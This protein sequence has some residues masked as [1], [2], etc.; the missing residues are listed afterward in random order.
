MSVISDASTMTDTSRPATC[1]KGAGGDRLGR[2]LFVVAACLAGVAAGAAQ[3]AASYPRAEISGIADKALRAM[4]QQAVGV[5]PS[6]PDSRLEA[7]RRAREA[8][9]RAIVV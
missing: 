5:A 7:R 4:I 2:Q 6:R 8:A 3:A 1:A 9:D